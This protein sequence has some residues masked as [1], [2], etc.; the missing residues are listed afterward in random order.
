[1]EMT[2]GKFWA[3]GVSLTILLACAPVSRAG[4]ILGWGDNSNN[5]ATPPPG[6]DFT[7]IAAGTD[8]SVALKADGSVVAWGLNL[9]GQC[10]VPATPDFK[11]VAAGE[12]HTLLLKKDGSLAA[13]GA[14]RPATNYNQTVCPPGNNYKAI[15]GGGWHSVALKTDGSLAAWGY[16]GSGVSTPPSG[17]TYTAIDAGHTHSIALKSDGSLVVWGLNSTYKLITTAPTAADFKAVAAGYNHCLALKKDGSLY[18]WGNNTNNQCT[19]PAGND[20]TA[21]AA[22]GNF[23]LARKSDGTVVAFGDPASIRSVPASTAIRKIAAGYDHALAIEE[24]GTITLTSPNG[25]QVWATGSVQTI[26][27]TADASIF[28]VAIDYSI[29]NGTSW[30]PVSPPNAGNTGSYNWFIPIANSQ[31]CLVRA[32]SSPV[33]FAKDASEAPFTIYQCTLKSDANGD[34]VVDIRDFAI[35]AEE[36]LTNGFIF[37]PDYDPVSLDGDGDVDVNDFVIFSKA[38]L[39]KPGDPNWNPKC[40]LSFPPDNFID[41]ADFAVFSAHWKK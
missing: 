13:F 17:N 30:I 25:G 18:A 34:C 2:T 35:M 26:T 7:D 15:A 10:D 23:S 11:A 8:F 22:K 41:E 36:W 28:D 21:I 3:I 29:D 16:S 32:S 12:F 5:Q 33:A 37:D 27:W 20:F 6:A 38:W 24:L 39:S 19:V 40:D 14:S 9:D 4:S 1:M 31:K